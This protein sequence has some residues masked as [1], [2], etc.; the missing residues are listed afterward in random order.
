LPSPC[1]CS[2]EAVIWYTDLLEIPYNAQGTSPKWTA[3]HKFMPMTGVPMTCKRVAGRAFSNG[4]VTGRN[5][6]ISDVTRLK[7]TLV[8]ISST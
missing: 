3:P 8:Q 5:R 6:V 7:F 1:A 2:L 4:E